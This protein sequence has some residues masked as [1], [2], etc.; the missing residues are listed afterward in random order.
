MAPLPTWLH[1]HHQI[2]LDQEK[3]RFQM[4]A[5]NKGL[6]QHAMTKLGAAQKEEEVTVVALLLAKGTAQPASKEAW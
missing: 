6:H 2:Q 1:L 3:P 5:L 4:H